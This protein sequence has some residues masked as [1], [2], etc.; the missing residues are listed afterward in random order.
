MNQKFTN[1]AGTVQNGTKDNISV[2]NNLHLL[3][4][5]LLCSHQVLFTW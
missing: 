2:N 4:L 5:P 1:V 3:N